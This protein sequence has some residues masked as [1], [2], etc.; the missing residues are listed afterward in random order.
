MKKII[1]VVVLFLFSVYYTFSQSACEKGTFAV[2]SYFFH[3]APL[4]FYKS[5][6]YDVDADS[7]RDM[8]RGKGYRVNLVLSFRGQY[9]F[10][11]KN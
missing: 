9:F 2:G 5:I 10:K 4:V 8:S 11:D 7:I 6:S 1:I 3:Y